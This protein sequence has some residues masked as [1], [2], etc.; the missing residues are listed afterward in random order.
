MKAKKK[1]TEPLT[2]PRNYK[3]KLEC[4]FSKMRNCY[5][6]AVAYIDGKKGETKQQAPVDIKACPQ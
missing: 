2:K 6:L 1:L 5:N 4:I 3:Y